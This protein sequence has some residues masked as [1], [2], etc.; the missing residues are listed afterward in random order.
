MACSKE[1]YCFLYDDLS[2]YSVKDYVISGVASSATPNHAYILLN[3]EFVY[4]ISYSEA[5]GFSDPDFYFRFDL[6]D[7]TIDDFIVVDKE[8]GIAMY[9][10]NSFCIFKI[11][12]TE[13]A[14]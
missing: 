13:L 10:S 6:T 1:F 5:S 3:S 9:E 11:E 8:F 12:D 4:E 2:I 14:T 7:S